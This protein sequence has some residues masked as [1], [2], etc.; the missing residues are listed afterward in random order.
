MGSKLYI[1]I[2]SSP[3][4]LAVVVD[5][6]SSTLSPA[7]RSSMAGH[8]W[9]AAVYSLQTTLLWCY[10]KQIKNKTFSEP[11]NISIFME[12]I[13]DFGAVTIITHKW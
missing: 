7:L 5:G 13:S 12:N 11:L 8:H 6:I 2:A 4:L 10:L 9:L 3:P 1:M